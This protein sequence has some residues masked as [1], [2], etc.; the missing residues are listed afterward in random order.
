MSP[1]PGGA[2]RLRVVL[3]GSPAFALPTLEALLASHDLLAVVSQPD[4]PA[5]RGL[6]LR[7]P[8]AAQ[9]ARERGVPV[10][11]PA[12]LRGDDDFVAT[13]EG[14]GADLAVTAAY[15]KILPQALLDV[16]RYGFLNVHA[17]LLPKYRGAAPIQW[18][19]IEG[20]RE[21]GVTIMQTEAGLDTGPIR[22]VRRRP[23]GRHDTALDL[24]ASLATLGAEALIDA[25]ELL[26]RH[27][28]PSEA[29]DHAA[30]TLAPLLTRDDGRIDWTASAE[31]IYNR[32]RGVIAWPGSWWTADGGPIKVH[33]MRPR[34]TGGRGGEVLALS[35]EGVL[36]A[37]GEGSILLQTVQPAGRPRMDAR[38][39]ARGYGV[40]GGR[41][42]P[43]ASE[44][45]R[46][47]E[48]GRRA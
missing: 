36:V 9:A 5:G 34:P 21:T 39:W 45:D 22:L 7:S 24:F 44:G 12:R 15:G 13:L 2:A 29:Q 23:I 18:A 11:Q 30:A 26:A 17:S 41:L 48:G 20:E 19:L 35:A 37:A 6:R 4:K 27:E 46:L 42:L 32:Y 40:V 3:F 16:P 43:G 47:P 14:L 31:R 8:A 10:L 1:A 38:A 25:L 33:A 28:L